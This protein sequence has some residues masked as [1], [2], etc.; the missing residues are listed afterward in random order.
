M[1]MCIYKF[2]Y[3]FTVIYIRYVYICIC[4]RARSCFCGLLLLCS[5]LQQKLLAPAGVLSTALREDH[6]L[7]S[8]LR[9]RRASDG[10]CDASAKETCS[11]R[12][13]RL[14]SCICE[15]IHIVWKHQNVSKCVYI[16]MYIYMHVYIYMRM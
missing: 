8:S 5:E 10:G 6:I 14:C 1:Y 9:S 12:D 13:A 3:I 4:D 16:Y 15:Y 2:T 7:R 11:K